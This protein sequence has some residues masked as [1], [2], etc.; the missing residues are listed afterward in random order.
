MDIKLISNQWKVISLSLFMSIYC[1]INVIKKSELW[2]IRY[3]FSLLDKSTKATINPTNNKDN[4]CFQYAATVALNLENS[5]E[6]PQKITKIKSFIN[7]YNWDGIH[8]PSERKDWKK[9]EK[10]N[11]TI[12]HNVLHGKKRKNITCL[13]FKT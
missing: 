4:K 8:F 5:K 6:D 2:W 9:I 13:Y 10:N 12:A 7:K 3:K 1:I 11:V